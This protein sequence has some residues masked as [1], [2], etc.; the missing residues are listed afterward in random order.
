MDDNI[1]TCKPTLRKRFCCRFISRIAQRKTPSF[2]FTLNQD[3]FFERYHNREK[4]TVVPGLPDHLSGV[5]KAGDSSTVFRLRLPTTGELE[6]RKAKFKMQDAEIAYVKL[7]GSQGWLSS[8]GAD[9]I[10]IGTRKTVEKEPLLKWYWSLFEEVISRPETRLLTVGYSFHDE[11]TNRHIAS[12]IG[13][14]LKL[15]VIL[16]QLPQNFKDELTRPGGHNV[17]LGN[18]LWT[19]LMEYW[20]GTLSDFYYTRERPPNEL[21]SRG[22]ALFRSLGLS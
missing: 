21:N 2:I 8:D 22:R 20:P 4:L 19:C 3:L 11:H 12:A 13:R 18:E 9:A 7:H 6:Q 16:P 14:G 5:L 10:V 1:R 17:P 15:Y